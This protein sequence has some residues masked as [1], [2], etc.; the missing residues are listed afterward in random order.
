MKDWLGLLGYQVLADERL[1]YHHLMSDIVVDSIWQHALQA[2]LPSS[3]SVYI[4]VARKMESPLTPIHE[5]QKVRQPN[6]ATAPS[7]GRNSHAKLDN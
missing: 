6:W 2:W 4:I 7:A 3:G 5:K 1:L